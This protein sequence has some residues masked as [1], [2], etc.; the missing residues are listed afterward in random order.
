MSFLEDTQ[1]LQVLR[2]FNP[3]WQTG[4]VSPDFAK[5]F[6]RNAYYKTLKWIDE[7]P[8]RRTV[9]LTGARRVGKTT[10][11]YQVAQ[12]SLAEDLQP[13]QVLYVS[14][15]HPVLKMF[16]L[17][18]IMEIYRT[19]I[20]G[21]SENALLLLDEINHAPD[22]S[23]WLKYVGDYSPHYRVVATGSVSAEVGAEHGD[24]GT[25]RRVEIVVPTLSFYEYLGIRSQAPA[26]P[27]STSLAEL[28]TLPKEQ[29]QLALGTYTAI[30]PLFSRYLL[31][32]GFPETALLDDVYL[33]QQLLRE[34][35][36]D[37]VLKR[38]MAALFGIRNV[39]D[40]EKVFVYLCLHSGEPLGQDS[41]AR[42]LNIS[43]ITLNNHL[44]SLQDAYLTLT[45][46]PLD[47]SGNRIPKSRSKV[48]V[49]DAALRNAV[50]LR[51]EDVLTDAPYLESLIEAL[52]LSHLSN[53]Y[54]RLRPSIGYWKSP[55][56]G[57][58]LS[59]IAMLPTKALVAA[60]V[61]YRDRPEILGSDPL[62]EFRDFYP[63]CQG[64]FVTKSARDFG[65]FANSSQLFRIPA[66]M[67]LYLL[68]REDVE[69]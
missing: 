13:H 23:T 15:D 24:T 18:R 6:R 60:Q 11:L 47:N 41:M 45:C 50:L 55:R 31:I 29:Q 40:L 42:E 52:V 22:W 3:W 51:G 46:P 68:G 21:G 10:I 48:Y 66:Y 49:T 20:L 37:R 58:S 67:F 33:S 39:H 19:N 7:I 56:T 61:K 8:T 30:E 69:N 4:T 65:P 59:S 57:K 54:Q 25:G 14:F 27:S 44:A 43:R 5:S 12:K 2:G 36:L 62:L 38:D 26:E 34:D 9:L 35:C 28:P 1:V 32:G 64:Y 16:S 63:H 53:Y 17:N